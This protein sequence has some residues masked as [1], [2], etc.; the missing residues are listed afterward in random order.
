[1]N[2]NNFNEATIDNLFLQNEDAIVDNY[3]I[4]SLRKNNFQGSIKSIEKKKMIATLISAGITFLLTFPFMLFHYPFILWLIIAIVNFVIY[5]RLVKDSTLIT[6][7]KEVKSRP[8]EDIDNIV[9]PML[10]DQAKPQGKLRAIIYV[11]LTIAL[12]LMI[13]AK[14]HFMYEDA[15][16]GKY[17]RFYT[18]GIFSESDE[19]E[20]P[21]MVDGENVV[22][23]RGDVFKESS[24]KKIKLP[25]MMDTIRGN[26]F[27]NSEDLTHIVLPENLS[28]L[29]GESF[30]GCTS[31]TE[32]SIPAKV[33]TIRSE[34]FKGC[35]NL[36]LVEFLGPVKVIG[37]H[38]FRHTTISHLEIPEGTTQILKA[39]FAR[40]HN[41]KEIKLPS[42]IEFVGEDAFEGCKSLKTIYVPLNF[43]MPANS[44]DPK[45]EIKSY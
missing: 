15:S 25:K 8:D 1:M 12:P 39:A 21:D 19:V 18:C 43:E 23:L 33:D 45:V 17:L 22:G 32:I 4:Q 26:S 29:G 11:G 38:A 31:L 13:F 3:I 2:D 9:A 20:I 24:L 16:N 27:E 36:S 42:T 6:I 30:K 14:P 37:K 5:F 10:Y 44:Y 41:L 28:Y 7:R 35:K 40:C 34:T